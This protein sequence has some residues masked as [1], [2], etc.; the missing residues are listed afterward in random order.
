MKFSVGQKVTVDIKRDT[1][2]AGVE[3]HPFPSEQGYGPFETMSAEESNALI[4]ESLE[5]GTPDGNGWVKF[6]AVLDMD[7]DEPTPE[8]VWVRWSRDDEE[9]EGL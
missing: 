6:D 2:F 7:D 8:S 1:P 5:R 4:L 9:S 3:R